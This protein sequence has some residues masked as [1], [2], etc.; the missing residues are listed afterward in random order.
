MSAPP[1]KCEVCGK[2]RP[3]WDWHFC[4]KCGGRERERQRQ[5]DLIFLNG[6]GPHS[7]RAIRA[8]QRYS[9]SNGI[10]LP[11]GPNLVAT[12][13]AFEILANPNVGRKTLAEIVTWLGTHNLTMDSWSVE[14]RVIEQRERDLLARLKAKYE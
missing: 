2:R 9:E 6:D 14:E 7:W 13:N 12:F 4:K 1:M 3:L 10:S 11:L 8:L 5:K